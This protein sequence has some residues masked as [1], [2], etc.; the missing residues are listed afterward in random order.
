MKDKLIDWLSDWLTLGVPA[1]EG[2]AEP[3]ATLGAAEGVATDT[4]GLAPV[5]PN[6]F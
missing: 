5:T 3:D 2:A 6:C 1:T 4:A